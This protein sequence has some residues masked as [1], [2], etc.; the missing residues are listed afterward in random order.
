[1]SCLSTPAGRLRAEPIPAPQRA[2]A[3]CGTCPV[4]GLAPA[5]LD[6]AGRANRADRLSQGV[7]L[8]AKHIPLVARPFARIQPHRTD[9]QIGR[10]PFGLRPRMRMQEQV[11]VPPRS[12][13]RDPDHMLFIVTTDSRSAMLK[14]ALSPSSGRRDARPGR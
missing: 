14:R 5:D 3:R 2:W 9:G 8:R 7:T 11:G 1:M 12:R 10:L 6:P 4:R 13:E